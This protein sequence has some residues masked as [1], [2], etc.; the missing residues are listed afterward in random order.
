ME[1]QGSDQNLKVKL[2]KVLVWSIALH[3]CES[4]TIKKDEERMIQVFELWLW[5]RV[6]RISWKDRKTNDW[7]RET[8]GVP[9]KEGLLEMVK[10]RKLSKYVHWKRRGVNLVLTTIEGKIGARGPREEEDVMNGLTT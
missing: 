3:G 10:K 4:W 7:V 5:R 9:E 8:I 1:I 2:A 6:L